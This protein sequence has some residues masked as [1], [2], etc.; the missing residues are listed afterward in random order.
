MMHP[1][2]NP[3]PHPPQEYTNYHF[4]VAPGHLRGALERFAQF[5]VA[6]LCKQSAME[7]EASPRGG[8]DG[9][10]WPE[11]CVAGPRTVELGEQ[12]PRAPHALH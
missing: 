8:G 10:G 4:E 7:R 9:W 12:V 5:F 11:G 2:P 6:P 1:P 3:P